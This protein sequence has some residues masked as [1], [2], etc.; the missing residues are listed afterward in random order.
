LANEALQLDRIEAYYGDSHVLH[1]VSFVLGEARLL[2]LLGRNGAGKTTSMNVAIGLLAPRAG[3]VAVRGV[4]VTGKAL[5]PQGRRIFRSLS[6]HE[7]L[8]VAARKPQRAGEAAWSFDRVYATF[9]RLKERQGQIAGFL[10]GG[11]QQMLAIGRALMGNPRVL[12]MDEPSEGLAPQ[13]VAEVMTTI[14]QLKQEGLSIVLV[15]QNAKLVFDIADDI[16]ILNSGQVVVAGTKAELTAQ[17]ID[18]HQHLGIY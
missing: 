13:I 3:R 4:D 10:S 5:V 9:P 6:V 1:A 8:L 15:E 14:R 12:L 11:E 7:N 17:N 18:L 2:G 16:V